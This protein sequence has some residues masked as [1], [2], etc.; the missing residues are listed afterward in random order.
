MLLIL[1]AAAAFLISGCGREKGQEPE[2]TTTP[3]VEAK[4]ETPPVNRLACLLPLI[5]WLR[6]MNAF[7]GLQSMWKCIMILGN[8]AEFTR[9]IETKLRILI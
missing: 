8:G 3:P 5:M 9:Q 4:K 1:L 6:K 7:G 2:K